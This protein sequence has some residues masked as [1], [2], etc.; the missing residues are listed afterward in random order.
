MIVKKLLLNIILLSCCTSAL[1]QIIH[2][3]DIYR[4]EDTDIYY[5]VILAG[6]GDF[7][8]M[9]D[10][11]GSNR[12]SLTK[13]SK[14]SEDYTL[15]PSRHD[16]EPPFAGIELG[17]PVKY[18]NRDGK[19]VLGVYT[20][21]GDLTHTLIQVPRP[22]VRPNREDYRFEASFITDDEE[23]VDLIFIKG[24]TAGNDRPC[25]IYEEELYQ[26]LDGTS[27]ST[28]AADWV[29]DKTDINFDGIPDLQ[30]CLGCDDSDSE[31]YAGYVWDNKD[32]RFVKATSYDMISNPVI[33]PDRRT[34]TGTT[35]TNGDVTTSTH[36]W[37]DG[38]LKLIK[39]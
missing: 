12:L 37:E 17:W 18:L 22:T 20:P 16:D 32:K 9:T 8:S 11:S 15:V 31:Y 10:E 19:G 23:Y 35:H 21:D 26:R 33:D 4:D 3:G 30:I 39:E 28:N 1:A 5:Y 34:I 29:N 2:E 14:L 6:T 36:V 24:Y 27:G 13:V 25:M 7:I 38:Q